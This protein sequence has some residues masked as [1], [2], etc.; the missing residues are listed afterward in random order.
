MPTIDVESDVYEALKA[1]AV[2]FEDTPSSVLRR[3][4]RL[5]GDPSATAR[6]GP[7]AARRAAVGSILPEGEYAE[8]ILRALIEA[9]GSAPAKEVT[10]RVGE[11]LEGRL[12]EQDRRPNRS[13]EIRWRNR[14]AFARLR[15]VERGLLIRGSRR[16]VWEIS[17]LGRREARDAGKHP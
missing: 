10:D 17:D 3:V 1:H 14:T 6:G 7:T 11:L 4:L 16:G 9:G 15:L 13:G 12:T 2:P 5:A 8:P